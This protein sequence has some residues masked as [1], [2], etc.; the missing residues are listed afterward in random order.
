MK[1]N[2][3]YITNYING[4][5]AEDEN[6]IVITFYELVMKEKLDREQVALFLEYSKIRLTNMNYKIYVTGDTYEYKNEKHLIENNVFYVAIK[7]K[8]Q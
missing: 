2:L 7:N 4:K 3:E 5:L 8:I 1:L 6:R